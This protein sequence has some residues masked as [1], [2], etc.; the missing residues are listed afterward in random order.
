M[1]GGGGGGKDLQADGLALVA[2]GLT[3]A[4]A[5]LKELGMVGEAGAGRGFSD[6]ALS[7]LELGHQGLTD[8]FKSFCERW[9]W[10]VRSLVNEGNGF[11]LKTGLSAGT[12]YE[13]EQYVEGSFKVVANAAI[14]NPYASED[15]VTQQGW[16]DIAKS[17]AYGG[18]DY[19]K[20][21]FDQA[22][23]NSEQ[24]WK[25]AGRDVM[26]SR[27]VGPMGLNPE[28]LHGAAGMS[29]AE[30]DKWLDST[31]GP[32]PEERAKAAGQ[33]QSGGE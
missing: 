16:G 24:G 25:D 26:T 1:T 21:S 32:S 11:A 10:G 23:A 8:D 2:K 13:T 33:Q 7:G 3:E 30:Y 28:N 20:E 29:D 9:E 17:G 27:T 15:E 6:I 14:G 19:S 18:V 5:E 4:L 31:F 12:Y 22:L